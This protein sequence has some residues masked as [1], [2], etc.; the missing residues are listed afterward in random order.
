M[1]IGIIGAGN[2]GACLARKLAAS[3]HDVRLANS[4]GLQTIRNLAAGGKASR[5]ARS[6]RDSR[7]WS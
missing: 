6:S 7:A 4:K 1:K 3:A 5:Y 2:I